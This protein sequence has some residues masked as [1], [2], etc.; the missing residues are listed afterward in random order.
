MICSC[1]G[2]HRCDCAEYRVQRHSRCKSSFSRK[3]SP[4][5]TILL[6]VFCLVVCV[7]HDFFVDGYPVLNHSFCCC[8]CSKMNTV[9]RM[10]N[11][12]GNG[13]GPVGAGAIADTLKVTFV[14]CGCI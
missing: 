5:N 14:M 12:A 3:C 8:V 10:L 1:T 7:L 2:K 11:L 13:I 6:F 9:L 4:G